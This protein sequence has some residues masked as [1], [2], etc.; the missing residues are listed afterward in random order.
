MTYREYMKN[1]LAEI[2]ETSKLLG[3]SGWWNVKRTPECQQL[4]TSMLNRMQGYLSI[5]KQMKDKGHTPDSE[6]EN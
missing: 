3:D 5:D 1:L 6:M 4:N 2:V